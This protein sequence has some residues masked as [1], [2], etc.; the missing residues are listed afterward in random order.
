MRCPRTCLFTLFILAALWH[1]GV[2]DG[3]DTSGAEID[4]TV[5]EIIARSVVEQDI[6]AM[7]GTYHP[8]AVLVSGRGTS[9]IADQLV[10]WGQGMEDQKATGAGATVAFR[11]SQRLDG[12]ETAFET[13]IF[14]YIVI[15]SEGN[16]SPSYVPFEAL[17]VRKDGTWLMVMERQLPAVD[18]AAWEALDPSRPEPS[19]DDSGR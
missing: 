1:P 11:F 7:A 5:W 8:D 15:D 19:A 16:K 3:D 10:V 2:S 13:G 17:L 9:R 12:E 18:E 4:R 6:E 14:N